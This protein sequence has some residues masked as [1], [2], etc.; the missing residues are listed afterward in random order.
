MICVTVRCED[1]NN[2]VILTGQFFCYSVAE[3]YQQAK[4]IGI[5]PTNLINCT[6]DFSTV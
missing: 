4:E 3:A 2:N 5:I 6:L 1:Y